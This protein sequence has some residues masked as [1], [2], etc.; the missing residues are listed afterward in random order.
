MQARV[1]DYHAPDLIDFIVSRAYAPLA[2][3]CDSVAHLVTPKT[4]LLTMKTELKQKEM[5]Q[6]DSSRY[7]FE[8]Q[9]LQVPGISEPRSLVS[10]NIL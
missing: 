5:L 10:I 1:Q 7:R 2:E 3:F 9:E 4:R 6:L 8:E